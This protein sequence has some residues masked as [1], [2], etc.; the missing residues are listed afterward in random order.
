MLGSLGAV[1]ATAPTDWLLNWIGWRSLFEILTIATLATAGLIY[2]AVPERDA[3]S[4]TLRNIWKAAYVAFH[5]F[6][7]ALPENCTALGGLHR[8]VLGAAV[9][10]GCI[11]ARRRRRI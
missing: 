8:I 9:I 11:L 4:Q 5:L 1:T 6:G 3:S 10:V 2:F 7:S